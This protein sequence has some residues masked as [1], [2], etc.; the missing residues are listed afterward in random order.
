M[1]L[2]TVEQRQ[3]K[4]YI[5]GDRNSK[6]EVVP[7]RG[8]IVTSWIV[9][10]QEIFYMDSERFTHPE[11]SV[12]GGIPILFPICGNMP[13]NTYTHN[14]QVYTL[15]QHGFAREMPWQVDEKD[16]TGLSL[17]LT[18]TPE[19]LAVYP[20]EFKVKFTYILTGN[21]LTIKQ[22][23]SNLSNQSMP[24]SAGTHAYFAAPDK[25]ELKFE[26]P[27]AEFIDQKTFINHP[28]LGGFDF[29][30]EEIDVMFFNPTLPSNQTANRA[31][32]I[33]ASRNL[34]LTLDFDQYHKA[35]VFWSVK[36]K[37]FFCLEPWTAARNSL[38]TGENLI[39]LEPGATVDMEI[40]MTIS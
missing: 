5:L 29:E 24:F 2:Y 30:L 20:F 22:S 36:G 18:S 6:I 39:T 11:L 15:K 40:S 25:S 31:I 23:Y 12:R 3:Y 10:D 33:D 16:Q 13:N 27:S 4:T 7:E 38:N 1:A 34:T 8:G 35:L 19:T 26:L 21:T 28:F 14:G 17:V 37:D 32:A 9:G